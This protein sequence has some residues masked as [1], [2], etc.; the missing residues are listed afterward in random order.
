MYTTLTG[1]SPAII[2]QILS[3]SQ[4]IQN[5]F[6]L[7]PNAMP[8]FRRDVLALVNLLRLIGRAEIAVDAAPVF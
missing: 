3:R 6:P 4:H 5:P 7:Y 1:A 2:G 8:G